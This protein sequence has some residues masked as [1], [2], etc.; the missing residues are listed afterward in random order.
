MLSRV[1]LVPE[2]GP[3]LVPVTSA[4]LDG[5]ELVV[6][7]CTQRLWAG[8]ASAWPPVPANAMPC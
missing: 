7:A 3:D 5:V 2:P 8:I 6:V 4:L 1:A